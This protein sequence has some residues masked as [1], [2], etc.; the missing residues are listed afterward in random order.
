MLLDP[1]E[2]ALP[3][4]TGKLRVAQQAQDGLG[5]CRRIGRRDQKAGIA[6][7]FRQPTAGGTDHR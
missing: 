5:Q 2:S 1:L 6:Y 4:M 3:Q 7:D